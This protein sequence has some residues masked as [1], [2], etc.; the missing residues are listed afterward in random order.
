LIPLCANGNWRRGDRAT[1]RKG[2]REGTQDQRDV[3]LF[4]QAKKRSPDQFRGLITQQVLGIVI[5]ALDQQLAVRCSYHL[6][7]LLIGRLFHLRTLPSL[8]HDEDEAL[9]R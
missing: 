7:E 4:D 2:L 8:L 5:D 1:C 9:V 3:R 6:R